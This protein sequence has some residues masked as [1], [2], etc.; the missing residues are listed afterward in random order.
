MKAVTLYHLFSALA[1]T[2]GAI[3]GFIGMLTV[4]RLQQLS[5]Y[6]AKAVAAVEDILQKYNVEF[7]FVREPGY[8]KGVWL[9]IKHD[10]SDPGVD[11]NDAKR[12]DD[13]VVSINK[14][15]SVIGGTKDRFVFFLLSNV[16]IILLSL[17]LI[18]FCEELENSPWGYLWT[19]VVLILVVVS[20]FATVLLCLIL[21]ETK[22]KEFWKRTRVNVREHKAKY[23]KWLIKHWPF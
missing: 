7:G 19:T 16:S 9:R 15:P 6:P 13:M 1:Q 2:Y 12:L 21:I 14:I 8:V 17:F 20:L 22:W 5:G 4:Y 11:V 3:I 18:P 10:A 23:E